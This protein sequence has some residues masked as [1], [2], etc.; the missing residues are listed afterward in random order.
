MERRKRMSDKAVSKFRGWCAE[1]NVSNKEL[2]LL[3]GVNASN[4]CLKMRG[5]KG[6]SIQQVKTICTTYGISADEFFLA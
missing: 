6:F 5:K 2:A 1:H 4:M 3:L